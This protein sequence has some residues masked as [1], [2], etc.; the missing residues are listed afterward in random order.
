MFDFDRS[1]SDDLIVRYRFDL[2]L[3]VGMTTTLFRSSNTEPAITF[4]ATVT[5]LCAPLYIGSICDIF[6]HCESNAVTCSNRGTCTN[7]LNSYTCV[8]N[9]GYTGAD[10]EDDI[11]ECEGQSCS[12]NGLCMDNV[13]SYTC[14]CNAG[15]TGADCEDDIDE[16]LLMERVCSDHGNCSHGI[17]SFT[18]SCD[19][20]YT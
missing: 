19:P 4:R 3:S 6:N 8:C 10:C 5:V 16:C 15:Y 9:A 14:V 12:G 17:A 18:C 20:G 2:S 7:G 11:D 1:T 13:N